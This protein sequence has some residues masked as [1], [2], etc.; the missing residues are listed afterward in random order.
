M[1]PMHSGMTG[2]A[3]AN[4]TQFHRDWSHKMQNST[5]A[6]VEVL[7]GDS[8]KQRFFQNT[9]ERI[10]TL[11]PSLPPSLFLSLWDELFG[12]ELA[13]LH[14]DPTQQSTHRIVVFICRA[15]AYFHDWSYK[16]AVRADRIPN[17]AVKL[18]RIDIPT[19]MAFTERAAG[20]GS[21]PLAL[22]STSSRGRI[23]SRVAR[24]T[25]TTER[26]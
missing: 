13:L 24:T 16:S 8:E 19:A 17:A 12:V 1:L 23:R 21:I 14:N 26:Y 7:F 3:D 20:A 2:S 4:V 9:K 10:Q 11:P 22:C 18:A 6:N 15:E 25:A 5:T